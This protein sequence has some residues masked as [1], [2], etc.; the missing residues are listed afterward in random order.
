MS[1]LNSSHFFGFFV[2]VVAI[3]GYTLASTETSSD[4]HSCAEYGID[5]DCGTIADTFGKLQFS[6]YDRETIY[7]LCT[8]SPN[9]C[10]WVQDMVEQWYLYHQEVVRYLMESQPYVA[11]WYRRYSKINQQILEKILDE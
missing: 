7:T 6:G 4:P 2:V 3:S 5:D 11:D 1:A 10:R 8:N 9:D